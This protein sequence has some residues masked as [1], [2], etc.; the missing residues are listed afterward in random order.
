MISVHE[1][2]QLVSNNTKQ[3]KSSTFDLYE[4]YGLVLA[5][6]I[7]SPSYSPPF[8]QSEMDGYAYKFSE[9][10]NNNFLKIESEIA[11]GDSPLPIP[12][13]LRHSGGAIGSVSENT[14]ARIFTGARVPDEYDTVVM[15]EKV[16]VLGDKLII[17]DPDQKKGM[18]IR[19][20][21]SQIPKGD[22]ALKKG[23]LFNAGVSGFL[24]GIGIDRVQVIPKPRISIISTGNELNSPGRELEPGK[25]YECNTYSLNAALSNLGIKPL[26]IYREKDKKEEISNAINNSLIESD[27]IILSG[28]V[29]VGDYDFVAQALESCRVKCIFHKVK[30]K[31][32]KPMYFGIKNKTLIFGLP[33]NPAALLTCFYQYIVPTIQKMTGHSSGSSQLKLTLSESYSK[34]PGLTHFLKG[35]INGNEVI[36]LPSQESY[37]MRSFTEANCLV[38]LDEE[39]STFAKGESVEVQRI[40]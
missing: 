26:A 2:N 24:A 22:L 28:G 20:K 11:A 18:N 32:G 7:Y 33:G 6:D 9:G 40:N 31:P 27:L 10:N 25:V 39:K 4:A 21:G 38:Q 37:I 13:R 3:L 8:N 16:E 1:A 29:S 14:A 36:I 15:Q 23:I 34:K 17:K 12:A 5:E 30:Q 35:K 19:L